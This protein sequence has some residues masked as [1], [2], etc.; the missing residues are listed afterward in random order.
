MG[1]T[2]FIK[3]NSE[4]LDEETREF[5]NRLMGETDEELIE[6]FN[7]DVGNKGWATARG[8][9]HFAIRSEFIRRG[10]DFTAIGGPDSLSFNRKVKLVGKKIEPVE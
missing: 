9:F 6:S 4:P 2:I 5:I 7:R 1:K 3:D 8:R 10:F